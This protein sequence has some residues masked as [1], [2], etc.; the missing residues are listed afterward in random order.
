MKR[1]TF[2]QAS[3]F[4]AAAA[5]TPFEL[6]S[7]RPAPPA[8]I[9]QTD[10]L[11]DAVQSAVAAGA[12][13]AEA[14]YRRDRSETL[15]LRKEDITALESSEDAGIALRVFS[16]GAWG[17][18]AVSSWKP[19]SPDALASAAVASA[20]QLA[21]L[22]TQD[23]DPAVRQT[24]GQHEWS[25]ELETDPFDIS[26]EEK[27]V[28]LRSLTEKAV[29]VSQIPFAVANLFLRRGESELVTSRD[30]VIRQ[31]RTF[32]YPNFAV[33]AFHQ[34]LRRMD[35][36]SSSMEAQAAGWEVT[37][38]AI[39]SDLE[40]AMQEALKLQTA[41]PVTR[42]RYDLVIHPTLLWDLLCDTI[43][44]HLDPRS[45]LA[46]D[47]NRPGDQWIGL[48]NLGEIMLGS[49][50]LT[51]RAD[52]SLPRGLASCGW[53]D[54]G[55]PSPAGTIVE[56]GRI[57][58]VPFDDMLP[59]PAGLTTVGFSRTDAW[60]IPVSAAMPNIVMEA[61]SGGTISDLVSAVDNGL[62]VKGRSRVMMNP[63]KTLFRVRPQ[64]AWMIRGG[65]VAEAVR[66]VEI[67]TSVEQFWKALD[68][69]SSA[70]ERITAGDLFPGR[71][72]ALWEVPFSVSVPAGVFRRIPV[73]TAQEAG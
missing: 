37:Q 5:V 31:R 65:T 40:T 14:L 39:I 43:L 27:I 57:V 60:N 24:G 73:Y 67:E 62:L 17:S 56:A 7:Y 26:I 16:N 3:A 50:L 51:L 46:L 25:S 49:E 41:D 54:S 23:F 12:T 20:A 69:L 22:R 55:R 48:D 34:K 53:D 8:P 42:D 9:A 52:S 64:M 38:E 33:T 10:W 47:G 44:P 6:R 15:Q 32:T 30:T 28:F 71:S 63:A 68:G 61:G 58:R 72:S 66:G 35:T 45:V 21:K 13:Y 36:R 29:S 19:G 1:R 59:R 4:T 2:L 11:Q 18:A 70:S